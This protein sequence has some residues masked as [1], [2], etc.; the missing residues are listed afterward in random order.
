MDDNTFLGADSN[1]TA[2]ITNATAV[3]A[4]ALVTQSDSLVLG[5]G[6][7]VGVGTSAPKEKLHIAGNVFVGGILLSGPTVSS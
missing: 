1:G 6:V 3:G 5:S 2:G 4:N 7:S